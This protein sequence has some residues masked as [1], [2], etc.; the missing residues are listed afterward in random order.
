MKEEIMLAVIKSK[1]DP[2]REEVEEKTKREFLKL[3]DEKV[4]PF[5]KSIES[6]PDGLLYSMSSGYVIYGK[7]YQ[8]RVFIQLDESLFAPFSWTNNNKFNE[9]SFDVTGEPKWRDI[10]SN[11]DKETTSINKYI[12]ELKRELSGFLQGIS[13]DTKL[14]KVFP[15]IAEFI[16][17][18]KY[19]SYPV[20]VQPD[21]LRKLLNRI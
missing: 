9:P 6:A 5:K 7:T 17:I 2:K 21:N 16:D 19:K 18:S 14:F 12:D 1:V 8:E 20:M 11:L 10:F 3:I 13:T 4:K 15:E